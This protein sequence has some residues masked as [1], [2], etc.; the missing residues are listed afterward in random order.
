MSASVEDGARSE[1]ASDWLERTLQRLPA[2]I[3]PRTRDRESVR[4]RRFELILLVAVAILLAVGSFYDVTRQVGIDTR[5]TADI[6]TWRELSGYNWKHV[7][8]EQDE[9]HYTKHD[10][11]CG[12]LPE[13]KKG[14]GKVGTRTQLCFVMVGPVLEG[15]RKTHT[16][17]FLPPKKGDHSVN[18]YGCF[19]VAMKHY[20]CQGQAPPEAPPQTPPKDFK[21]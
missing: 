8:I 14:E 13:G 20:P 15:R 3:R 6:E 11:A 7:S 18:R 9:K 19:G 21:A 17:F 16:G 4:R 10:V 5:L 2:P 1:G 12:N